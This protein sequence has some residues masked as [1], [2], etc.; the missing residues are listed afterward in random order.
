MTTTRLQPS[1]NIDFISVEARAMP[2]FEVEIYGPPG[3]GKSVALAGL[4][5][6][7]IGRTEEKPSD[8]DPTPGLEEQVEL[9]NAG[10]R[11]K[12]TDLIDRTDRAAHPADGGP[13]PV[14]VEA[15]TF[16]WP[17]REIVVTS[18]AGEELRHWAPEKLGGRID[19]KELLKRFP[20]DG[21]RILVAVLN[22][23]LCDTQLAQDALLSLVATLQSNIGLDIVRAVELACDL[24]FH[25]SLAALKTTFLGFE[26][27]LAA[28]PADARITYDHSKPD[29]AERFSVTPAG[30]DGQLI[31]TLRRVAEQ[32]VG[33]RRLS[34][35]RYIGRVVRKL[36][37]RAVVQLT[38]I[39]LLDLM[40]GI[41]LS[42]CQHIFDEVFGT[43]DRRAS[44]QVFGPNLGLLLLKDGSAP[45]QE[46]LRV[47]LDAARQLFKGVETQIACQQRRAA[48]LAA[49]ADRARRREEI[50]KQREEA[51]KQREQA[52]AGR[53][54]EYDTVRFRDVV[55]EAAYRGFTASPLAVAVAAAVAWWLGWQGAAVLAWAAGG[56][57]VL[58]AAA[59]VLVWRRLQ[60][61]RAR[62]HWRAGRDGRRRLVVWARGR[63]EE[64]AVDQLQFRTSELGR[65]LDFGWVS[66]AGNRVRRFPA[67][68]LG[69][70]M[71][72]GGVAPAALAV[73][74]WHDPLVVLLAALLLAGA[75]LLPPSLASPELQKAK[76]D[77]EGAKKDRDDV[78]QEADLQRVQQI[79]ARYVAEGRL[80]DARAERER[81]RG[82]LDGVVQSQ[83]AADEKWK[84]LND[85]VGPAVSKLGKPGEKEAK[86]LTDA[87]KAFKTEFDNLGKS[88][89][90]AKKALVK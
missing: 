62:W 87:Q 22:P 19:T 39:D 45:A 76:A 29:L 73:R 5:L 70:L 71:T 53:Q 75:M 66:A 13:A 18:H 51:R 28:V 27:A 89:D 48:R 78:K 77:A 35:F 25:W 3:S 10:R 61:A 24:L 6:Y 79:A 16:R 23:F 31:L 43:G 7:L 37:G 64:A 12:P 46:V 47:D 65:I 38:H 44:Q 54:S 9:L 67:P 86:D 88:V 2:R 80:A 20:G 59:L 14:A 52:R 26:K 41:P 17:D 34:L 33:G 85:A 36:R 74:W 68:Q 8:S 83:S 60:G 1:N 82:A 32:L 69:R 55:K 90:E 58:F 21:T 57:A 72:S 50:R 63:E 84:P 49:R 30:A 40:P 81:L 42:R 4:Y 56:V 11:P 15:A